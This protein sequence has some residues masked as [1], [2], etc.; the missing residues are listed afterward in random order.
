LKKT[1]S[2]DLQSKATEFVKKVLTVGVGTIFLTEESIRKLVS[3]F[4]LPKEVL[5]GLLDSAANTRK[6]FLERLSSELVGQIKTS[7]DLDKVVKEFMT[8]NEIQITIKAK[9][10]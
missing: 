4:K 5:S 1:M 3:D 9:K 6:E 2:D 10:K 8:E 7:V